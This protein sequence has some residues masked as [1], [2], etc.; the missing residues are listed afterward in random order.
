MAPAMFTAVAPVVS[1][2]SVTLAP[3][4]VEGDGLAVKEVMTGGLT[5]VTVT[6]AVAV[7]EPKVLVAVSV[8]VVVAVGETLCDPVGV[9][10]PTLLLMLTEVELSTT[11]AS[12]EDCPLV[13][14]G[15][16]AE[17]WM[18]RGICPGV[19]V[20]AMLQDEV[21]PPGPVARMV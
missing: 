5:V 12:V 14:L 4:P 7:T 19:T 10:D 17:N 1:Q 13:M 20:T 16:V 21:A 11:Q 3:D 2:V 8:Y 6:V 9:T 18:I 15:G